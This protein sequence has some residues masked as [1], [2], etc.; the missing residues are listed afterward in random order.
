M[1]KHEKQ[2]K[3]NN[4]SRG[5]KVGRPYGANNKER[6]GTSKITAPTK[7]KQ[8]D[9]EALGLHGKLGNRTGEGRW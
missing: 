3:S 8:T 7:K 9:K 1:S 2:R 6:V 4:R 5:K